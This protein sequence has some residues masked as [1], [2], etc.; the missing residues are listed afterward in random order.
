[1]HQFLRTGAGLL[2]AP[3]LTT[4]LVGVGVAAVLAAPAPAE[5]APTGGDRQAVVVTDAATRVQLG[6]ATAYELDTGGAVRRV[7]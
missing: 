2:A 4:A 5:P 3:V 6:P 1:M 7:R